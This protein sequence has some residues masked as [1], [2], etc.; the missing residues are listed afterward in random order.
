[1]AGFVVVEAYAFGAKFGVDHIDL[2]P[3]ADGLVGALGLA[4]T[5]VD[6]IGRDMRCHV[7]AGS[8][9]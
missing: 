8:L 2:L 9:P 4:S 1:L 3:F 5:A 7:G 6:A